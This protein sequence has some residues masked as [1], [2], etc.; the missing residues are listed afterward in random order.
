MGLRASTTLVCWEAEILL[1][2]REKEARNQ[3]ANLFPMLLLHGKHDD[4][5]DD[6]DGGG[7]DDDNDAGDGFS[8]DHAKAAT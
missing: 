5:D 6:N 8:C 1:G 3:T 7:D 4:D 2:A